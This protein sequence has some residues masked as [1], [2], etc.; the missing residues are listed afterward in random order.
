MSNKLLIGAVV[1]VAVGLLVWGGLSGKQTPSV[2]T[3]SIN[4]SISKAYLPI[5]PKLIPLRILRSQSLAVAQSHFL[6]SKAKNR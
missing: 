6:I 5:Q 1:V 4:E 3:A 2:G